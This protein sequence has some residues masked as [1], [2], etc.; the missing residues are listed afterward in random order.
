MK[1]L[2]FH[3]F[4]INFEWDANALALNALMCKIHKIDYWQKS[5]QYYR[6][7]NRETQQPQ[8]EENQI[9]LQK[10]IKCYTKKTRYIEYESSLY[11]EFTKHKTRFHEDTLYIW[12]RTVSWRLSF[13]GCLV[14]SLCKYARLYI[15]EE[16]HTLNRPH[17]R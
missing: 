16:L 14:I 6:Q 1:K 2:E 9:R 17:K 11:W 4:F 15:S 3:R 5:K 13:W 8:H 10:F 7:R 12:D